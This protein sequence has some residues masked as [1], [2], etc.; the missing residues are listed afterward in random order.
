MRFGAQVRQTG[1]FLA[2]LTRAEAMG[3][4]VVQL[5][6]QNNRQW[7]SPV[8]DDVLY[9]AYRRAARASPVVTAT[10]CHAPYLINVISPDPET[11]QRSMASLVDNLRAASSLGAFGLVLH[12]GSHRGVDADTAIERIGHSLVAALDR[13][14]PGAGAP[15]RLLLENTA[16]S[17]NAVGRSFEELRVLLETCGGDDRLGV[18]VD[19]QHLWASGVSFAT[20]S[21]ADDVVRRLDAAVGLEHVQCLHL[22][23]SKVPLGANSD[24]HEN[25]GQGTIG[26]RALGALLSHPELQHLPAVLEVPGLAGSGPG[27]DDL[28]AARSLHAAGMA[29]RRRREWRRDRTL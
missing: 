15:C 28:A 18:C 14:G 17:G 22:N 6:A 23:D 25:L 27:R 3:A 19:T 21:R 11:R 12:P 2:A 16:G 9:A 4:E 24:R 20:L 10:V 26:A 5:F 1:G 29:A 13:A 8:R 7:R